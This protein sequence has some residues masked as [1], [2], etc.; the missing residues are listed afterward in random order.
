MDVIILA[1]GLGTRLRSVINSLPKPMAP[2][3][4]RPFL[5]YLLDYLISQKITNKFLVSVGYEHQKIIDHFGDQYKEYELNYL[6]EDTPLGTGGAIQLALNKI[7]TEQALI[8]N[9]DTLFNVNLSEMIDFHRKQQADLTLALKLLKNFDR[10]NNVIQDHQNKV[11]KFEEKQFKDKG[12]INGGIYLIDKNLISQFDLPE[13]F[14]FEED[15]LKPCLKQIAM[16]GFV[17]KNYFIDIGIPEDYQKSQIE[18]PALF[19]FY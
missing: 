1:G 12:L 8:V 18:L 2:V 3:A 16:Y 4:D 17:S 19:N 13:K 10:Y 6:I 5:E 15:F 7:Q 14:S 9:G 11:I